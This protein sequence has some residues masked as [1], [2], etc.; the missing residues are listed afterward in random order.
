[1]QVLTVASPGDLGEIMSGHG[2]GWYKGWWTRVV[3]A[4]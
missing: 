3:S 4:D 2:G 1:M